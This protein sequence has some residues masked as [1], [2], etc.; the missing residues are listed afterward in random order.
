[1][2]TKAGAGLSAVLDAVRQL[3]C[4]ATADAVAAKLGVRRH[5]AQ[6]S[7]S[8]LVARGSL[9]TDNVSGRLIYYCT[10]FS[11][12]GKPLLRVMDKV[13]RVLCPEGH[14]MTV[15]V[16][17]RRIGDSTSMV[18]QALWRL[19]VLGWV[20]VYDRVWTGHPEPVAVDITEYVEHAGEDREEV[21]RLTRE[22]KAELMRNA[23]LIYGERP[24]EKPEKTNAEIVR[25]YI[26]QW[27][28]ERRRDRKR[29]G[30]AA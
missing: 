7:L 9:V 15:D 26:R 29:N 19:E 30:D 18:R 27:K 23:G 8:I 5:R 10:G 3:G 11:V 14:K 2:K 25:G 6:T 4:A 13:R 17:A 28:A 22:L 1:M 20:T 12:A 16:L 24:P 21:A